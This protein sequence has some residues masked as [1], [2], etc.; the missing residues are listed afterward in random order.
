[1]GRGVQRLGSNLKETGS[2]S[3]R[4]SQG[5]AQAKLTDVPQGMSRTSQAK[6]MRRL[7]DVPIFKP[8]KT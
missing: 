6:A 3:A 7:T 4:G 1:M 2:F 5:K 8:T